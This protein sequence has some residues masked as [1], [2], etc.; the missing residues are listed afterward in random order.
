MTFLEAITQVILKAKLTASDASQLQ[1]VKDEINRAIYELAREKKIT[2]LMYSRYAPVLV[3]PG[4]NY[5]SFALPDNFLVE[6]R[7][8]IVSGTRS[9]DLTQIDGMVPPAVI[10]GKPTCF[11]ING[12]I[13]V[14]GTETD[15][16]TMTL[17][18]LPT[19][20]T[21]TDT[22]LVDYYRR[23]PALSADGDV[24][25]TRQWDSE[26]IRRVVAQVALRENKL[27]Q[28]SMLMRSSQSQPQPQSQS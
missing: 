17:E 27:E 13:D 8:Y 15:F 14:S 28:A 24:V 2:E 19:Q 22:L 3:L 25:L 20:G 7:V 18:T 21:N 11:E 6:N 23:P 1:L 4:V 9:W 12:G 26:V 16:G 10:Y 5:N